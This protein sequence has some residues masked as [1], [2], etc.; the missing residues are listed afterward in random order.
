METSKMP[1]RVNYSTKAKQLIEKIDEG[2]FMGLGLKGASRSKLFLFAMSLGVETKTKTDIV[3]PYSGGLVQDTAIDDKTRASMYSQFISLL[4]DPENGLD[5]I[6]DKG[7]VY[8]HTEQ[9]ANTGFMIIADYY[10]NKKPED[11]IWDLFLELDEQYNE[12]KQQ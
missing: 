5:A 1:D 12:I 2:N 7:Q 11:L 9:Y 3:N 10:E 4:Q 6:A 8:K